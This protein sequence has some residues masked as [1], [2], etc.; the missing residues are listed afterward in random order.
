LEG[1]VKIHGIRA[2][3]FHT[4]LQ[5]AGGFRCS[6][7]TVESLMAA[8]RNSTLTNFHH[9]PTDCPHREKNGWTG[10]AHISSEQA[11]YNFDMKRA[12]LKYVDDIVDGQW[13]SGQVPCIAPTSVYGYNFQSG[14]TWVAALILIPWNLYRF[15]GVVSCLERY[16]PAMVR[17]LRYTED[18]SEDHICRS[19]LGDFLPDESVEVCPDAMMLTGYVLRMTE[20]LAR[21]ADIMDRPKDRDRFRA[22]AHEIKAAMKRKFIGQCPE[23]QSYLSTALYFG[24][25][26]EDQLFAEKLNRKAVEKDFLSG[27]GIFS[28]TFIPEVLTQYGYFDTAFKIVTQDEFPGW[29]YMLKDGGNTLWEHWSGEQGSLNHHMRSP[30]GAWFYRTL[31]G[32]CIDDRNPGFRHT[33]LRP[34]FTPHVASLQVW[35]Q[36]PY[37][38]LEVSYDRDEYRVSVPSGTCATLYLGEKQYEIEG[39][40]SFGAPR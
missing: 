22:S 28:S 1:N 15:Y 32:I 6:N 2:R 9:I 25:A 39:G 14:P 31:A 18:I 40:Q 13:P 24:L 26:D 4:D 34:H 20:I 30:I 23:T 8:A 12:Y 21:I 36:T 19:G 17:Y 5:E 11:L 10:D 27:G 38:K 7:E 29:T 16:Y 37:G 3:V 35:H 33:I